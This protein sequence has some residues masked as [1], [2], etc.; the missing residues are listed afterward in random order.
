MRVSYRNLKIL[1]IDKE[2]K[3]TDLVRAMGLTS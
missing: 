2:M 3:R 1:M